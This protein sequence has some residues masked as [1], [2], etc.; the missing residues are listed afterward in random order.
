MKDFLVDGILFALF[1]IGAYINFWIGLVFGII[2]FT[3][4]F[5]SD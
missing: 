4:W 2:F 3:Y 5:G 1:V